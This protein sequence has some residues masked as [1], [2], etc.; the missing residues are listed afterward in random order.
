MTAATVASSNRTVWGN[1]HVYAA[2]LTAPADGYTVDT[3]LYSLDAATLTGIGT[4]SSVAQVTIA[5]IT[6]ATATAGV[7]LT[8]SVIGTAL[9]QYLIAVG[10]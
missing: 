3:G 10:D 7:T 9:D 5:S 1:R 6:A 8:L 4:A 2:K